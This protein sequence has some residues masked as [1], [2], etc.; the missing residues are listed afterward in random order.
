MAGVQTSSRPI[1]SAGRPVRRRLRSLATGELINIP[2]HAAVWLGV[3]KAPITLANVVG[4]LL[5]SALLVQG[6]GYW[7]AKLHQM[8]TRQRELPG[9]RLFRLLR[10]ANLPVL[11][12]GLAI[13]GYGAVDEPGLAS[14]PGLGYALFAVLEH[15]N[16]F[17][18]QLSYDR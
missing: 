13:T 5:F 6:A 14:W 16:Y 17:Y 1:D 2:L 8:R 3:I 9:L 18:L 10:L 7:L 4:F 12:V 15:V 11:A